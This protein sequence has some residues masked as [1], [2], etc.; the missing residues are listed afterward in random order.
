M[1]EPCSICGA[2]AAGRAAKAR[3]GKDLTLY[4]CEACRFDFLAHDPTKDLAANKLDETRLKA[5]GLDIP[6]VEKDFANGVA[7]SRPY[8]E[9]YIGATDAGGNV[10][11]IGCS[12]GYFLKLARDA[13]MK[14]YGIEVNPLR[15]HYVHEQLQIPC[16]TSLEACEARGVKFRKIFMFY[17]L[18]Y[19]PNPVLYLQR[20]VDM[21]DEGGELIV[22]TPNLDDAIKDLWRNE[23]FR[24]FFYDE[25]AINYMTF[26][27]VERMVEKLRKSSAAVTSRQGY[28]FVNH[29]SW[30]L[31]NAPR[32]TGVVGGDNFVRDIL[33][34]LQP[35]AGTDV[36]EWGPVQRELAGRLGSL[37]AKFDADYRRELQDAKFGNQVR[38]VVRR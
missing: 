12:W 22:V 38:I 1:T 16:D 25:H 14:P 29:V 11:E 32:T 13:G 18:E 10:L 31:T 34:Q 19:V 9:E 23:A 27:T 17:V 5:A 3:S 37:I 28:S 36:P 30:F 2:A 7:Q 6:S 26:R 24:K 4:H 15:A 33:A 35:A 21:L 8:V 20:L